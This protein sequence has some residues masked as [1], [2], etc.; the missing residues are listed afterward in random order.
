MAGT[1]FF[2]P[3]FYIREIDIQISAYIT[4]IAPLGYRGRE[5]QSVRLGMVGRR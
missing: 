5:T 4:S 3:D 1:H 2:S